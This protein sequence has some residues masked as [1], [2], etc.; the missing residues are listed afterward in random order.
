MSEGLTVEK[1]IEALRPVE[2]PEIHKSLVELGMIRDVAV[3]EGVVSFKVVLTT[4]A[5]PMKAE[6]ERSCREAVKALPGVK[7]VRV[8]FGAEVPK[9]RVQADRQ[10]IEGVKNIIAVASGKGGVGKSTVSVNL[11]LALAQSGAQVGLL[12]ADIHGPNIPIM[13]GLKNESPRAAGESILPMEIH[14]LKVMSIGVLVPAESA[15]IWRGPMLHSALQQFFRQVC[16]S[17]LDYLIVD[18]PPGTGDVPLSMTQTVPV[19]GAVIVTTPQE[20][21]LADVRK[22]INMFRKI[23]VPILGIVENMSYFVCPKCG[24]RSEIFGSGG[25]ERSA[26]QFAVPLLGRIPLETAIRKGGDEGQP[27][28]LA[29]PDSETAGAFKAVAGQVAA[30]MSLA[31]LTDES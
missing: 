27:V 11:A 3:A 2:D 8:D 10:P 6:I 20:V 31:N 18:L 14:G 24:E 29:H 16:W 26:M 5:C 7:E 13:L 1:V 23:E 30:Q 12:D 28:I 25:G 4:P 22:G 15:L 19:S 17:P 9:G 21:A